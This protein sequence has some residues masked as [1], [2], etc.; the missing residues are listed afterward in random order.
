[1]VAP[2]PIPAALPLFGAALAGLGIVGWR[3]RNAE[4]A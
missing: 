4:Q 2:V 1:M 3:K